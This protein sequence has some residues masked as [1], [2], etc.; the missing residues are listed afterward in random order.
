MSDS[1]LFDMDSQSLLLINTL[2]TMYADNVRQIENLTR[3]NDEIRNTFTT[4]LLNSSRNRSGNAY[5]RPTYRSSDVNR[6]TYVNRRTSANGMYEEAEP[7]DPMRAN[8]TMRA[9]E[10]LIRIF[11]SFLTPVT[12]FP[13]PTQVELATRIVRFSEIVEPINNSCPIS[14]DVFNDNDIVTV[15]RRCGHIF[16]TIQINAWFSA[17]CR[18]PICRYDIRTYYSAYNN[19]NTLTPNLPEPIATDV[20][21]NLT[22]S[23]TDSFLNEFIHSNVRIPTSVYG[24]DASS[25]LFVYTYI[26]NT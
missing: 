17:N 1:L 6:R 26:N 18:C 13:T 16:N 19:N 5:R 15:I 7:T 23:V 25:N 22:D 4:V 2:N 20:S 10:R 8:D 21:A 11:E 3:T 14:L 9:N 12:V 24:D